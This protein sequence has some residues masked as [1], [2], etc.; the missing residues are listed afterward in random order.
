MLHGQ[1]ELLSEA[2]CGSGLMMGGWSLGGVGGRCCLG[3]TIFC[4]W[5]SIRHCHL[6]S[7]S[8]HLQHKVRMLWKE[9]RQLLG[10]QIALEK[11]SKE[12]KRLCKEGSLNIYDLC[13]KQQQVG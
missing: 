12:T 2:V 6:L 13:T 10:E 4:L 1:Y 8:N 11:C 3:V 5:L 7:E 9:N